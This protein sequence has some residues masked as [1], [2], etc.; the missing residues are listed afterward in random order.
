MIKKIIITS[1]NDIRMAIKA[2]RILASS[3]QFSKVDTQK[4]IVAVSELSRNIIDHSGT[5]GLVHLETIKSKGIK[6]I[7]QDYGKGIIQ[8]DEILNGQAGFSKKGLGKGLLGAKRLM[9]D[10]HIETSKEG[11][12]IVAV[13]WKNELFK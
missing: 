5:H 12:K 3:L 10:F 13:K 6:V 1:E 8:L 4:V 7:V 2:I 11:T 9:D